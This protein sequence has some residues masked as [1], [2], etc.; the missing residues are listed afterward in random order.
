MLEQ[1]AMTL[2]EIYAEY[3]K[4]VFNLALHYVQN[5]QDAEEITQDVFVKVYESLN[6]FKN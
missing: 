4:M 5:S 2:E 3:H 1:I 6:G